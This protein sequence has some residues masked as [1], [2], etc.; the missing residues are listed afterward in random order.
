[1]TPRETK[2]SVEELHRLI[3]LDAETGLLFWL[4]RPEEMF[5]ARR[6]WLRW[7]ARY[8]GNE[9]LGTV[10]E[11]GHKRGKIHAGRFWAHRVVW[12]LAHGR[13]PAGEIDHINGDPADNR[14]ENLRDGAPRANCKNQKLRKSNTTGMM[15]VTWRRDRSRWLVRIA[16]KAGNRTVVGSFVSLDDAKA[17]RKAAEQQN[18]Y[19]RNHGR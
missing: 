14:P 5:T 13:W 16:D 3:R 6:E 17:A 12:A 1:M 10:T 15:G 2:F 4:P 18:G 9:A 8:A 19:H 11:Y 7:N